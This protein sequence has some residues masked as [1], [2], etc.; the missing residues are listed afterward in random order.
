MSESDLLSSEQIDVLDGLENGQ[1]VDTIMQCDSVKRDFNEANI[2][3][4]VSKLFF[5]NFLKHLKIKS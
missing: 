4:P 1:E 3:D 2:D 5:N